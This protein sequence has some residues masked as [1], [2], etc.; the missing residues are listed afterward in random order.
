MQLFISSLVIE[1]LPKFWTINKL[2]IVIT[3]SKKKKKGVDILEVFQ[4]S[5]SPS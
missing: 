3:A 2:W 1:N 4:L 5:S